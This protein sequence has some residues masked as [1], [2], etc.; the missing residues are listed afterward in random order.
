MFLFVDYIYHYLTLTPILANLYCASHHYHIDNTVFIFPL[1][2]LH[3]EW[4]YYF[5]YI[6]DGTMDGGKINITTAPFSYSGW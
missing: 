2:L 5:F 6:L 3:C 4:L 1:L